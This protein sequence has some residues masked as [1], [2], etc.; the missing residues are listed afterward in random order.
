M[1]M[2]L[3]K[4]ITRRRALSLCATGLAML[5]NP[6]LL[7]ADEQALDHAL[8][9]QEYLSRGLYKQANASLAKA[10][11]IE[12]TNEWAWGLLGRA[13]YEL[14]DTSGALECFHR[15]LKLTPDD[16]LAR[17]MIERITMHP[18]PR[19]K[20]LVEH[21]RE[22]ENAAREEERQI[23]DTGNGT[24]RAGSERS[25]FQIRRIVL[26]A[27]HGG[28][29][30]GAVGPGGTQEKSLALD[31]VRRADVLFKKQG[32]FETFLTRTGDYFVP[33]ASRTAAA[34]QVCADLFLSFHI[35][36][37]EKASA[38][39]IETFF[40]SEE[41]SSK[42]AER[43]ALFE[44]SVLRM[45]NRG[46][47]SRTWL[48]IED[49]LFR[50]E[51]KRY[52]KEGGRVAQG[53]QTGFSSLPFEGRGVSSASFFVLRDARMPAVLLET[54]FISNPESEKL[55]NKVSTRQNIAETVVRSVNALAG[56]QS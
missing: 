24:E 32:R 2:K 47:A 20:G 11:S 8:A 36:A 25:T 49:I 37:S 51:R 52:W 29:D 38:N 35:N 40:C 30:P 53:L 22:L 44:N 27:G 28:L 34:N 17:M 6:S 26:D 48:D 41:A 10:V 42:E 43:V 15:V 56:W 1:N 39:G 16:T 19:T 4:R 3:P 23:L 14:G 12:P 50:Y 7:R 18:R 5:A 33:L 21:N 54:G 46:R 31:I 45:D 55:L 9:G 13:K